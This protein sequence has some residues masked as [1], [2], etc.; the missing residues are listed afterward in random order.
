M[1]PISYRYCHFPP[2]IIQHSV[3]LYARFSLSFRNVEDLLAE[4]G[5]DVSYETTCDGES[6]GCRGFAPQDLHNVSSLYTTPPTT[7]STP[8]D[9]FATPPTIAIVDKKH[10]TSGTKRHALPRRTSAGPLPNSSS[11]KFVTKPPPAR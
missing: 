3:W 4:R 10:L 2:T 1:E 11:S 9:I 5:I 7:H 8:D 6:G